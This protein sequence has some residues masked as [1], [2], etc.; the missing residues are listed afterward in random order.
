[1][2]A[3][4][5]R[6][7]S[8]SSMRNVARGR[9]AAVMQA[10]NTSMTPIARRIPRTEP[11]TDHGRGGDRK[12]ETDD[13]GEGE[14]VH[15]DAV[16]RIWSGAVQR[17]D[18]QEG[19]EAPLPGDLL[20]RGRVADPDETLDQLPAE[21]SYASRPHD[22]PTAPPQ[23]G[24]QEGPGDEARAV[25]DCGPRHAQRRQPKGPMHERVRE[26][27]A[28]HVAER[29]DPQRRDD[30]PR[31]TERGTERHDRRERHVEDA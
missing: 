20:E 10:P 19:D 13:E 5:R 1:M 28:H 16:G 23:R 30:V 27:D 24:E 14:K 7:T 8:R 15:A 3:T 6:T 12:P 26:E 4:V 2:N 21:R 29:A 17:D 18:P 31:G 11:L 22:Q 9:A 25:A